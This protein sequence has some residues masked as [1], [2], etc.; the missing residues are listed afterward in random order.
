MTIEE[1]LKKRILRPD[2]V[3][4]ALEWSRATVYFKL[5]TGEI[6][7]VAGSKPYRIPGVWVRN[8]LTEEGIRNEA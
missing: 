1:I 7:C 5:K 4:R 3:A 2:E 6:P 8:Q